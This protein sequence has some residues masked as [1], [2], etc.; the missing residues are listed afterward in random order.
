MASFRDILHTTLSNVVKGKRNNHQMPLRGTRRNPMTAEEATGVCQDYDSVFGE[1]YSV[2]PP[3]EPF[4][5]S[6]AGYVC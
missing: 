3:P 1:V 2:V 5:R 6:P 4:D